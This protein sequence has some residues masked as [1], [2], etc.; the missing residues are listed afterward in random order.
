MYKCI[1]KS[2]KKRKIKKFFPGSATGEQTETGKQETAA[3]P[4]KD[5]N[6]PAGTEH[7]NGRRKPPRWKNPPPP[8]RI[9]RR[10][11]RHT[12][13]TPRKDGHPQHGRNH[14]TQPRRADTHN[15]TPTRKD[16]NRQTDQHPPRDGQHERRNTPH[17]QHDGQTRKRKEDIYYI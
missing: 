11:T 17:K 9:P 4:R 13:T 8:S 3:A 5:G 2:D 1:I 6:P 7:G 14:T 10:W 12:T 16:G 15:T